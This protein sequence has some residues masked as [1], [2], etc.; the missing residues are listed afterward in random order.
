MDSYLIPMPNKS[1]Q[2]FIEHLFLLDIINDKKS[3]K[4]KKFYNNI[5]I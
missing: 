4:K 3:I 5:K 1:Y 2:I